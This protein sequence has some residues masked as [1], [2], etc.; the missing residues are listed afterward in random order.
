M[1]RKSSLSADELSALERLA[2]LRTWYHQVI[3]ADAFASGM[4]GSC[5]D[6][7]A[8]LD[9]TSTGFYPSENANSLRYQAVLGPI[10]DSDLNAWLI[11]YKEAGVPYAFASVLPT[12][13]AVEFVAWLKANN[14]KRC[15]SMP[16]LRLGK[17]QTEPPVLRVNPAT[18][19]DLDLWQERGG[20]LGD[21]ASLFVGSRSAQVFLAWINSEPV[22]IGSVYFD[23]GLAYLG[24]A[25]TLEGFRGRGVQTSLI[26]A[27]IQLAKDRDCDLVLAETY[28]FL[29]HSWRN[30]ERA[31]FL[32]MCERE[33]YR[34][35]RP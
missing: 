10:S 1:G 23:D 22:G 13:Y 16:V 27:R 18:F 34:W 26:R 12:L 14:F 20:T 3:D 7:F 21:R 31:G 9:P 32:P 15:N 24:D 5:G 28:R 29:E 8:N 33:I 25:T 4:S 30:L 11:R 35:T 17:R 2:R 19:A 6:G